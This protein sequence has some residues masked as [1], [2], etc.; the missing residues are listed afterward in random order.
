MLELGAGTGRITIPI[1]QD[2]FA[3]HAVDLDPGMLATLRQ[4]A[5][6]QP[7]DVAERITISEGDMRSVQLDRRF[8]LAI[9]PFRAFLHNLT[10]RISSRASARCTVISEPEGAL[11]STSSI[12]RSSS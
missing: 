7:A 1:A 10:P 3:I 11:P 4:K 9:I 6:A 2:G 8:A 12:R 5:A